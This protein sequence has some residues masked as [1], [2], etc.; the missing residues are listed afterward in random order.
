MH[1]LVDVCSANK[2]D[3]VENRQRSKKLHTGEV[4]L[5]DGTDKKDFTVQNK[6]VFI[7]ERCTSSKNRSVGHEI[8]HKMRSAQ[9][10]KIPNY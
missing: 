3:I 7:L 10:L 9:V 8:V 2:T 4:I 5:S 1:S 6:E